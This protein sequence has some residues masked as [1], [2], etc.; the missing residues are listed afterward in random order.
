ME[1]R[2]F[3][4]SGLAG[5]L[6]GPDESEGPLLLAGRAA[7]RLARIY[8]GTSLFDILDMPEDAL[9]RL[10]AETAEDM[11]RDNGLD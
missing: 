6:A 9:W 5:P 1:D 3:F 11:K 10:Y 7:R 2:Q 8:G 4:H